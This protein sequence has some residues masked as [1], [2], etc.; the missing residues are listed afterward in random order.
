M[1]KRVTDRILL[2]FENRGQN[3]DIDYKRF[4]NPSFVTL[5]R[6]YIFTRAFSRAR[7]GPFLYY[8]FYYVNI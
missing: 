4:I 7:T 1:V 6:P 3:G 8:S 2:R 5:S